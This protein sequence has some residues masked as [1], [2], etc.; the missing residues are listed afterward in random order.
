MCETGQA[1]VNAS[2]RPFRSPLQACELLQTPLYSRDCRAPPN[3]D[4]PPLES[5]TLEVS[6]RKRFISA[7]SG[8]FSVDSAG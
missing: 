3:L 5:G 2:A 6:S 8:S 4:L 1:D 7:A